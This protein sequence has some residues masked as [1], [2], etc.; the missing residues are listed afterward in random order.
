M[1]R[2][3]V[4]HELR[5]QEK[6][7][8]KAI[9][10]KMGVSRTPVREAI[11]RLNAEGFLNVSPN[12]WTR[13]APITLEEVEKLSP[14]IQSLEGI[15]LDAIF[16]QVSSAQ[17]TDLEASISQLDQLIKMREYTSAFQ[18]EEKVYEKLLAIADNS[19]LTDILIPLQRKFRRFELSCCSQQETIF[20][21]LNI[22]RQVLVSLQG[23]DIGVALCVMRSNIDS[24]V[25]KMRSLNASCLE[26]MLA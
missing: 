17:I 19:S 24:I 14:V 4:T 25:E 9:A 1:R 16:A 15:A 6:I 7:S 20:N 2:W 26:P 12:R 13:V 22:Y 5:P 8:D 23:N 10:L 11:S 21:A 18:L 3:I